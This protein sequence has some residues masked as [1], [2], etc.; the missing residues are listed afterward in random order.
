MILL[1]T[2]ALLFLISTPERLSKP[3]ARAIAQAEKRGSGV[4]I[5]SITLWEIALLIDERR[6]IISGST[7]TFL[8]LIAARPGISMLEL[9]PEVAALAFQFTSGFPND[10]ADRI[11]GATARAYGLSLVTKDQRIQDCG[12]IK[13]IW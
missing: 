5:A 9:T 1:D 6:I 7:E 10:P 13:T 11:I 8:K 2:H 4:A 12:L 3:A